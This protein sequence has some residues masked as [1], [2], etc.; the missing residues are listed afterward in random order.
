MSNVDQLSQNFTLIFSA[1]PDCENMKR[2]DSIEIIYSGS[3]AVNEKI[4]EKVIRPSIIVEV[5]N[6][7]FYAAINPD[8]GF[9]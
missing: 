8:I 2:L 3:D 4:F 1:E 5:P 6:E 9:K 7:A